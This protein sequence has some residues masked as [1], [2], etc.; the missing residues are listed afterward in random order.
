MN[1]DMLLEEFGKMLGLGSGFGGG[2]KGKKK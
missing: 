1:D 2:K